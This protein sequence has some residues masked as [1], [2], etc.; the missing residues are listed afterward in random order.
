MRSTVLFVTPFH[1]FDCIGSS[2]HAAIERESVFAV[3]NLGM[4]S[5]AWRTSPT[6][7]NRNE[8]LRRIADQQTRSWSLSVEAERKGL[9]GLGNQPTYF[10]PLIFSL[11]EERAYQG[12][13]ILGAYRLHSFS[14]Y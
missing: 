3:E 6:G 10:S 12:L 7:E 9:S 2:E 11:P 14:K 13:F 5:V 1:C 8:S 4:Q